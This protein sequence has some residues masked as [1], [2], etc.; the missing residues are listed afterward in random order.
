MPTHLVHQCLHLD[1]LSTWCEMPFLLLIYCG[2][3]QA[4]LP[5]HSHNKL[6]GLYDGG[7]GIGE[8]SEL[9]SSLVISASF[10]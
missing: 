2:C 1:H 7:E 8:P 9:A 6:G 10:T 5:V 3:G 4:I